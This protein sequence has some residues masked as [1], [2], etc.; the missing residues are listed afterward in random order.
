MKKIIILF[1]GLLT[2]SLVSKTDRLAFAQSITSTAQTLETPKPTIKPVATT[3]EDENIKTLKDKIAT[4]VAELREKNQIMMTGILQKKDN[5]SM[6]IKD[7]KETDI[8]I[9]IDSDLTKI[10]EVLSNNLKEIKIKDIADNSYLI[11]S[12]TKIDDSV[13]AN[14]IYIDTEYIVASGKVI[15]VNIDEKTVGVLTT[16]KEQYLLDIETKTKQSLLN[17]KT[18]ETQKGGFSKLKVG[19]VIHFVAEKVKNEKTGRNKTLR[20]LLIPQEFFNSK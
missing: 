19:D 6:T 14:I 16:D 15:E 18:L 13:S 20:L 11:I 5:T 10:Y 17:V 8:K 7:E 1:L 3:I 12:G 2:V 4:K 9:M